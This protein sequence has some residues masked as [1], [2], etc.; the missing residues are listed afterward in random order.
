MWF[1]KKPLEPKR[2]AL[3]EGE[4]LNEEKAFL[5]LAD[6]HKLDPTKRYVFWFERALPMERIEML[7]KYLKGLDVRCVI[8][9]GI[10]EPR[11]YEYKMDEEEK[12]SA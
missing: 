9:T 10:A 8:V 5:M 7:L 11:I 6:I 12:A 2:A 3:A 4:A 1:K